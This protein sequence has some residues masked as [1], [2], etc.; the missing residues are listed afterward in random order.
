MNLSLRAWT[1]RLMSRCRICGSSHDVYAYDPRGLW[2]YFFRKTYCPAHC[3]EHDYKHDKWS[4]EWRCTICD[5][6]A[7]VDWMIDRG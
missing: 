3:P 4:R 2:A 7:P 1:N 5:D 6:I